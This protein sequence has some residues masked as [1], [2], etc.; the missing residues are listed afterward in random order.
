LQQQHAVGDLARG[1]VL[2]RSQCAMMQ[3]QLRQCLTTKSRTG[4]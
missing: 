1:V 2:W 3:L 4:P